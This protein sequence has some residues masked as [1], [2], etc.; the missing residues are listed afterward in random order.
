[1]S[2]PRVRLLPEGVGVRFRKFLSRLLTMAAA[3]LILAGVCSDLRYVARRL[4]HS[5]K[6]Q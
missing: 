6:A 5:S 2:Q 3:A 4:N 1:M